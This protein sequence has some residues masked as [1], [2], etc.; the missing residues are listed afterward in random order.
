MIRAL[1]LFFSLFGLLLG[2]PVLVVLFLVG[3]FDTGSPIFSQERVGLNKKP[4]TLVKFRTMRK[5]TASVP[6]HLRPA[7]LR[8][9]GVQILILKV[10]K[11]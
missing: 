6:S 9:A 11:S 8:G 2:L 4:F 10:D 7:C 1:D 5:G 3:L